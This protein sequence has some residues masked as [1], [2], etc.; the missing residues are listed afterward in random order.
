M[1][2]NTTRKKRKSR[3]RELAELLAKFFS[4]SDWVFQ[5]AM[6]LALDVFIVTGFIAGR[7]INQ[8][9]VVVGS[10]SYNNEDVI[11]RLSSLRKNFFFSFGRGRA[12]L[13]E[14]TAVCS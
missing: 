5:R 1:T 9:V 10:S 4:S 12:P 14:I 2:P 8:M 6:T 13:N 7:I 11:S 3:P